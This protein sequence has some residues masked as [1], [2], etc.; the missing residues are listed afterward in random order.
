MQSDTSTKFSLHVE[1]TSTGTRSYHIKAATVE[2]KFAWLKA[3]NG[4]MPLPKQNPAMFKVGA[5]MTVLRFA[6]QPAL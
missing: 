4:V 1:S 3:I 2:E 5:H 6:A